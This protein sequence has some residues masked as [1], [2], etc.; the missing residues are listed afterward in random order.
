[1]NLAAGSQGCI[2]HLYNAKLYIWLVQDQSKY[3]ERGFTCSAYVEKEECVR[4]F[5]WEV[6]EIEHSS[7]F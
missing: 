6:K 2:E 1:M 4:N 7:D 5:D 3:D